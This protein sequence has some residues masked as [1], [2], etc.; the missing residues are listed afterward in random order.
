MDI[1]SDLPRHDSFRYVNGR[2]LTPRYF[3][4]AV[5]T[6]DD[7]WLYIVV[8]N[9]GSPASELISVFTQKQFNHA[10]LSFDAALETILSYNGGER[11]YPPGLNR[12]MV[13]FMGRKEDAS[14][15]VYRLPVSREQ[16]ESVLDAV[17]LINEEG[18]A[19]NMLGLVTNHSFKPNIMFCSQFVYRML[20]IADAVYFEAKSGAVKP[21]DFIE[22]DYYRK[23]EFVEEIRLPCKA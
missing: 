5:Q 15:L 17:R 8:S 20:K 1:A 4:K 12:E 19:Y 22:R 14:I 11:L 7:P 23:L 16:K 2:S 18:S 21:T 10:S 3:E 9:T 6:L 13:E